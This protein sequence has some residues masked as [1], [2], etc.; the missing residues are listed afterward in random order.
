MPKINNLTTAYRAPI[1]QDALDYVPPEVRDVGNITLIFM[2]DMYFTREQFELIFEGEKQR[3]G[4]VIKNMLWPRERGLP[5]V[6]YDI[7]A[8]V[9]NARDSILKAIENWE[10]NTCLV[11]R[12]AASTDSSYV[13][14]VTGIGCMSPVGRITPYLAQNVTLGQGCYQPMT[15]IHELGHAIGF[16]HEMMRSDRNDYITVIKE[17]I[18][19]ANRRNFQMVT[20]KVYSGYNVEFDYSSI[21][22][23][24]TRSFTNN[25]G[26]TLKTKDPML[27]GI[28]GT[29]QRL[30]HR[31]ALLANRMYGCTE[32]WAS[33]CGLEEDYCKNDGYLSKNCLCVCPPGTEGNRCERV[34]GGYYDRLKAACNQVITKGGTII[35]SPKY[36]GYEDGGTS[37]V[38][39]IIAPETD[40][41]EITFDF[42]NI[43]EFYDVRC[44]LATMLFIE[45]KI[46]KT[47]ITCGKDFPPGKSY[48]SSTNEVIVFFDIRDMFDTK[49]YKGRVEFIPNESTTTVQSTSTTTTSTTTTSTTTTSTTTT[50]PTTPL[51]MRTTKMTTTPT[52]TTTRSTTT[53]GTTTTTETTHPATLKSTTVEEPKTTL[54]EETTTTMMIVTT[55]HASAASS[56]DKS[57]KLP[58]YFLFLLVLPS[59]FEFYFQQ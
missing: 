19:S 38:Y 1:V 30:S 5:T 20:E 52:S 26:L 34:V 49:G 55:Q 8:D 27:Q 35:Q 51:T 41:I 2:D 43:F 45:D 50:T 23:Y 44:R 31:D 42:F 59:L 46:N 25:G 10:E 40:L 37:C 4:L 54:M 3:K 57:L 47:T 18:K 32:M 13:R 14:F 36:P 11:F 17:N 15:I 28:P 6:P 21:M 29:S 53:T 12:P 22:M 24:N 7:T 33:D 56:T 48:K 39:R 58:F 9:E 16:T